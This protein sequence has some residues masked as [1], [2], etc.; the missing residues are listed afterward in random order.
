MVK[1]F[2]EGKNQLISKSKDTSKSYDPVPV[3]KDHQ[4][5]GIVIA[6]AKPAE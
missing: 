2:D 3:D 6:I 4:I 1:R 5:V